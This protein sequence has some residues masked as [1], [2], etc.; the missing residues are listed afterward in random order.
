LG[1]V[2]CNGYDAFMSHNH[3]D[4]VWTRGLAARLAQVDFHGRPL[5]VWLDEQFLDPGDLG[6]A[7][8]LTSALD[9]SRMLLLVLSPASVA[10]KWVKFEVEYFLKSRRLREV[11]PLLKARCEIPPILRPTRPLDFS[12]AAELESRFG[13]LVERFCPPGGPDVGEAEVSIDHAWSAALDADPGGFGPKPTPE[14]DAL[15]TALL[16]FAIDDPASEGLALTGFLRA[17]RLLLRD[18]EHHHS[19]AYNMKML[20]GECLAVAVH[21]HTR[22]RQVAQRYLDLETADSEDPVLGFVVARAYSKLAEIDPALIDLGALLRV[23][24][25]LDARTPLNNKK[26]TVALLLGR[27]AAKLR[28]SDLG[29]LL[30]QTL[31]EG[32]AAAH[33]AAIGGI[34]MSEQ[35]E[36]PVFYVGE[37]ART[38]AGRG[39]TRSGALEPPSPKLQAMLFGIDFRQPWEVRN[40]LENAKDDLRRAFAINDLPYDYTWFALQRVSPAVHLHRAPFMGAV[41]K[42]TTANMEE[43]ALRLNASHVV[44]LTEPRIVDALFDRAGALLIPRQDENSPQCLRLSGRGVPFAMLDPQRISDLKDGDHIEIEDACIRVVSQATLRRSSDGE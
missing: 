14:R 17:A 25:Q 37:L 41:A 44:C 18:H 29:D 12:G 32:G 33:I 23:A 11:V 39:A 9:R 4:K 43:L 40:R 20:L 30:I 2:L 7:A 5:R 28:G 31:R 34:S 35:H 10:S 19:A 1:E 3:A 6:Q 24:T 36:P 22:Y 21:H 13:E 42:A 16:R 26:E 27:I 38:Y 8:E 15:L